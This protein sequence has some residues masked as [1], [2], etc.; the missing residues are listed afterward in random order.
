MAEIDPREF[1]PNSNK[2][3]NEQIAK[4]NPSE[5][6]E[7]AAVPAK[8]AEKVVQESVTKR[9]RSLTKRFIDIFIDEDVGDVKSY[10][11]Y[12][13]LVPAIKENVADMINSA[14]GLLLFGD[15]GR[16]AYR[17]GGNNGTGSKVNYNGMFNGGQRSDRQARVGRAQAAHDF[18]DIIFETRGDAEL[19]LDGMLEL[20]G[21]YKQV[22]VADFYD[23]AGVSTEFTDNKY[24]WTNLCSA[25]VMG[26][27]R[28]G[29]TLSLPRCTALN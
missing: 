8:K 22:S 2:Y 17:R 14:V 4:A 1:Q 11:I 3:K 19:V 10:L 26:S 27:P 5:A 21:D 9:K 7:T 29:Y 16:R 12:D 28:N 13:V 6:T 23:L 25:R 18:E 24:G 15:A 20:L